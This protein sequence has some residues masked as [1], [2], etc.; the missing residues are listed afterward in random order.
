MDG[1]IRDAQL[2]RNG[3]LGRS[4]AERHFEAVA[5]MAEHVC[6]TAEKDEARRADKNPCVSICS[7]HKGEMITLHQSLK[8]WDDS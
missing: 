4:V 5:Q 7:K 3:A 1:S 6:K 2:R 8:P